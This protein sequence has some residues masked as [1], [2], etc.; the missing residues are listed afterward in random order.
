MQVGEDTVRTSAIDV[1]KKPKTSLI[2]T[3]NFSEKYSPKFKKKQ[4]ELFVFSLFVFS[5]LWMSNIEEQVQGHSRWD[6]KE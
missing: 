3:A 1:K 6:K 2:F 4:I 5:L